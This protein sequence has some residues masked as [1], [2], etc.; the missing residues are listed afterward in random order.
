MRMS[1]HSD[2]LISVVLRSKIQK[3]LLLCVTSFY[4]A[5]VFEHFFVMKRF[6]VLWKNV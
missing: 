4:L 5:Y 3:N 6:S 2:S 1:L